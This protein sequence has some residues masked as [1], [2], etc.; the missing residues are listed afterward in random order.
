MIAISIEVAVVVV[1]KRAIVSLLE[2]S[3]LILLNVLV[4][5]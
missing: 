3:S 1:R 2:G 5:Q 4:I